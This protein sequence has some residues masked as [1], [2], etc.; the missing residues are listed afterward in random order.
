MD[1]ER[2][3]ASKPPPGVVPNF[4]NPSKNNTAAYAVL[5]VC[6]VLSIIAM[7]TRV[8]SRAFVVRKVFLTDGQFDDAVTF[9]F[10]HH[11][12]T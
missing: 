7:A 1:W 3:P 10:P 8:V 4:Q 9:P 12:T 2:V 11:E 6:L 5:T